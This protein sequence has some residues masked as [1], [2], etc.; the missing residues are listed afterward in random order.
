MIQNRLIDNKY[1]VIDELGK[2]GT[3]TVYLAIDNR[4]H[5]KWAI[6]ALLKAQDGSNHFA[7]KSVLSEVNLMKRIDHPY[8]PRIIDIIE[9]TEAIYVVMDYIEGNSLDKVVAREG[10]QSEQQVL[11]WARQLCETLLYLHEQD[12]PIIYRDMKP[13]NIMLQPNGNI[14]LIDLG[15][16]REYKLELPADTTALGTR[17]YAP[18][19]QHGARQTDKRSDIYALGMTLHYLL[20][21]TDPRQ[22][23]YMYQ[24]IMTLDSSISEGIS[25][26]IDKC[27]ALN[28]EERYSSCDELLYDLDHSYLLTQDYQGNQRKT[29]KLYL[30]I[31][32][33]AVLSTIVATGAWVTMS[34]MTNHRYQQYLNVPTIAKIEQIN[35]IKEAVKLYPE[36]MEGYLKLVE[37]Y[38]N[39]GLRSDASEDLYYVY[40]QYAQYLSP[41]DFTL[42]NE[43]LINLY[44]GYYIEANGQVNYSNIYAK[45]KPFLQVAQN[46]KG[47]LTNGILIEHVQQ[48]ADF[49]QLYIVEKNGK[50]TPDSYKKVF[51]AVDEAQK[52]VDKM[53]NI[54]QLAFYRSLVGFIKETNAQ[55]P[56]MSVER[57]KVDQYLANAQKKVSAL[58]VNAP[59]ERVKKEILALI[60]VG[61]GNVKKSY[62]N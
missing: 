39:N 20:T 6:K 1:E 15:I 36:R 47:S 51:V 30:G 38:Q 24:S 21:G 62:G 45:S 58:K 14:K 26:I 54:E 31:V 19:E 17:G 8:L 25:R 12:P 50:L 4:L 53:K 37:Y 46:N 59:L 5:K 44:L 16:A 11:L 55:M 28:P 9:D 52:Q 57:K 33:V 10:K 56:K 29:F 22:T 35:T 41:K 7:I 13:A 34:V 48:L 43:Q 60:K 49:Y 18:P 61:Q 32:G 40:R 42:L 23:G 3:S 2:G 27:T